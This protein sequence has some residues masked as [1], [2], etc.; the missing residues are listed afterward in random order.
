MNKMPW[1]L[2]GVRWV[3]YSEAPDRAPDASE[4][5]RKIPVEI[6]PEL[7]QVGRDVEATKSKGKIIEV[8]TK[9]EAMRKKETLKNTLVSKGASHE[10]MNAFFDAYHPKTRGAIAKLIENTQPKLDVQ[11]PKSWEFIHRTLIDRKSGEFYSQAY[12]DQYEELAPLVPEKKTTV[13]NFSEEDTEPIVGRRTEA[14][15]QAPTQVVDFAEEDIEP[16]V[17]QRTRTVAQAPQQVINFSEEDVEPIVS[18][19]EDK[20]TKAVD[21]RLLSQLKKLRA[22]KVSRAAGAI[23]QP[24]PEKAAVVLSDEA[25]RRAFGENAEAIDLFT[26]LKAKRPEAVKEAMAKFDELV[27]KGQPNDVARDVVLAMWSEG[28]TEREA[29][30]QVDRRRGGSAV[31]SIRTRK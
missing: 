14:V 15:A 23:D 6:R 7:D 30:A 9:E 17:V 2:K 27:K 28:L 20:V 29:L 25:L 13:V 21:A 16:I 19:A 4:R 3:H 12:V 18:G 26:K 5:A 31:A 11:D 22:A 1:N 10:A 8:E 24:L